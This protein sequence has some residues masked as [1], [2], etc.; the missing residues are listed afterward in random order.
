MVLGCDL[1]RDKLA[2][3]DSSWTS[4]A[5]RQGSISGDL[6]LR[7]AEVLRENPLFN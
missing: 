6:C 1:Y 5:Q 7:A 2:Q 4:A 3:F